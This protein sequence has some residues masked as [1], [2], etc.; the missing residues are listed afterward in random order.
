[1]MRQCII[2]VCQSPR[3]FW[4]FDSHNFTILHRLSWLLLHKHYCA[5]RW[6]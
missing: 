4:S 2:I 3:D 6:S 1:M 5:T